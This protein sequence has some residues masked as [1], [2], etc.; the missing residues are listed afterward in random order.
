MGHG[1]EKGES[2]RSRAQRFGAR[3]RLNSNRQ[4]KGQAGEREVAEALET[5]SPEYHRQHNSMIFAPKPPAD[6]T[7]SRIYSAQIDHLVVGPA[8]VFVIETKSWSPQYVGSNNAHCPHHQ[9]ARANRLCWVLLK[10]AGMQ[11]R[12]RSV[13]ACVDSKLPEQQNSYARVLRP[14]AIRQ[15]IYGFGRQL[16]PARVAA[17]KDLFC[18]TQ[19]VAS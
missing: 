16:N 17:I 8:G 12:V 10:I 2:R 3:C 7:G 18:D 1:D 14:D 11:E 4:R 5:L 9:V 15:H 13:I 6:E 19:S